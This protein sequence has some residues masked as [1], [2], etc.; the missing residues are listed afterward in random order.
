MIPN[1]KNAFDKHQTAAANAAIRAHV[2]KYGE[3]NKGKHFIY[4]VAC[5]G[6]TH[7]IEVNSGKKYITAEVR[8]GHRRLV[9]LVGGN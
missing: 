2:D 9:H 3:N 5:G 8:N 7:Q 6:K 4:E 1:I